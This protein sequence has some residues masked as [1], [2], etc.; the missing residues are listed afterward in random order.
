MDYT[1]INA[2]AW[3]ALALAGNEWAKPISTK[4]Y[5]RAKSGALELYLTPTKPVPAQWFPPLKDARVLCLASGGG[6]QGPVFAAH[7]A[8]VTVTDISEKQLEMERKVAQREGYEITALKADMASPFPFADAA[9]DLIFNPISNCY[10]ADVQHQWNECSRVLKPGGRLLT[11]FCKEELFLF[12]FDWQQDPPLVVR[13]PLPFTTTQKEGGEWNVGMAGSVAF[14]HTLAEQIGG[15]LR[16]GF[17]LMD[18]YEDRDRSGVFARYMNSYAAT[19][20]V[21]K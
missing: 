19:C 14:S 8:Q 17:A 9:F 1:E 4:E 18:L 20:A 5:K 2:R 13:N 6:Q 21:K 15:Q 10:I 7:G 16:A 3:D 12:D 11:G